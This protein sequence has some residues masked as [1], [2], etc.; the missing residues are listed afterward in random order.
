MYGKH[1]QSSKYNR[2][3]TIK[4]I[5]TVLWFLNTL[6]LMIALFFLGSFGCILSFPITFIFWIFF[7]NRP[8]HKTQPLN[9]FIIIGYGM[10][11]DLVSG[12]PLMNIV[13]QFLYDL[14]PV[15]DYQYSGLYDFYILGKMHPVTCIRY[16][17]FFR[18][19]GL[20]MYGLSS[21]PFLLLFMSIINLALHYNV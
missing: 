21:Y 20:A 17:L 10:D 18:L 13:F 3:D 19:L 5:L 11:A 12:T 7:G 15:S 16:P 1:K 9:F 4:E 14:R 6:P 8:V 2:K